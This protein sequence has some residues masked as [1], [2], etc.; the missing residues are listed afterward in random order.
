MSSSAR[1]LRIAV[2]SD[3]I[4]P[5][6]RGGKE[7]RL[8][9]LTTNLARMGHDVHV[10]TMQWWDGAPD[11]VE[12]GVHLH[13]ISR[14]Y[15]LYSGKRRSIRQALMFF[16]A[17]FKLVRADFDLLEVDHMPFFP[18]YAGK[19]VSI[20][21]RRP[22][23]ATWHEVWGRAYWQEY[24]GLGGLIGYALERF[25]VFLPDHIIAV[26]RHT[27]ERLR[28]ML[29]Y[30]G[31]VS[32][33]P[34]GIDGVAIRQIAPAAEKSDLMYVG[35]LLSHKNVD[36]LIR[37]VAKLKTTRPDIRCVIVGSGPEGKALRRLIGELKLE[38]NVIMKG[39]VKADDE[40]MALVKASRVFV[41]PSVREGF[42]VAALEAGVCGLP[43]V[44]IDHPE[45]AARHL[46]NRENGALCRANVK[47][48]TAA[49]E[50]VMSEQ[51]RNDPEKLVAEYNWQRIARHVAEV[52]AS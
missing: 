28:T 51:L 3:A 20:I 15:P 23:Y 6:H 8:H 30:G 46:V 41:L 38:R 49:I 7:M 50:H 17:C 34:N 45:N 27:A 42:G 52:Y 16:L 36:L 1:R 31:E 25:S 35:R 33:A 44:T 40:V 37:A 32:I 11:R 43:L 5:Y 22:M 48:L 26:S 2:V 14:L 12:D 21:K 9:H 10:Y 39:S 19:I 18:L 47:S 29:D 4:Y 13:A 24:L